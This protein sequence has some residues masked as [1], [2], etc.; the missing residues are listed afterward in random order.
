MHLKRIEVENFKSFG[1]E[2]VIPFDKGFTAI[3]GPNG[4]GK[5]NSGD[6]IQFVLGP[7]STKALRASN[8]SELIFNGGGRG[9]AA[10][11]MSVTLVFANVAEHDGRRRLRI[12]ED[13]VSFTR[14]VRLNRKGDPIS[15]FRIGDKPSS[16]TEMRRVLAEAGLRGD[17]YNIVLQG[18]VTN[19]A[20]MTPH[21]RRG[22]LEDVA[23]VTAYDDEIRRATTQRKH[24]ESSIETI[25]LLEDDKKKQLK[26]LS[27]EREQA[28]KY[29]EIKEEF[30]NSRVTLYQS[31]YRNRLDEVS[32][33][34][35]ERTNYSEKVSLLGS[36]LADGNKKL[37]SFDTELV[38]VESELRKA[39]AGDAQ[40]IMESIRQHEIEIE[41]G[42]DR[43]GDQRKI[44]SNSNEE[45]TTLK[46]ELERAMGAKDEA[47]EKLLTAKKSLEDAEQSLID[48][49]KEEAEA[50]KA[51]ESGDKFARDLN[52]ALGKASERV[53]EAQ[54]SYAQAQLES[55]RAEQASQLAS[56][57]L[58]DLE[59]KFEEATMIKDDLELI[60]NDIHENGPESDR[61]SLADD[62]RSLQKQESE[63]RSDRDRAEIRLRD[64]ERELSKAKARQEARSSAPG[65][66]VTIA[67]L[68]RLRESGQISGILGTLGE[69]T[70]PKDP[71]HEEALATALGNGLRSIVVRDDE[72]AAKCI[73]WLREN[74]GGRATFLPLNKLKVS[75]PQGRTLLVARNPGI[76]GFAQDL[77][78]YDQEVEIAV[79]YASRNTLLV[80]SME[81][82]RNNMGGVRMVTLDGSLIE[83]SGAMTGGSKSRG[84]RPSFGGSAGGHSS[85]D[86]HE[87]LVQE[88]NLLYS[89]V[90]A[91]LRETMLNLQDLRNRINNVDGSDHSVKLRNW[92]AD[93]DRATKSLSEIENR[94]SASR[95]EFETCENN[96]SLK[97]S[98]AEQARVALESALQNRTDAAEALQDN[99]PD[100]LSEILRSAERERTEAER[101]KLSCESSI[102]TNESQIVLMNQRV[103]D[104]ETR[105][106]KQEEEID[107]AQQ[108]ISQLES[109]ISTAKSELIE[110]KGKSEQFDEEHQILTNR[111]D[112]L[113]GERAS[114][115]ATLDQLSK[116]RETL[117]SRIDELNSQISQKAT[118]AEETAEELA[119]AGVAIPS[120]DIQ[121]PTIAEAE[122]AMQG[123]ERRLGNLGN[124][125][126]LAIDQY[127]ETAERI[128]ALIE[129]GKTLRSR[130]DHL[131]S[132]AEQLENE[133]KTR[134]MTVFEHVNNN[135]SRVYE[136][137]QPSGSGKLRL[138][139]SKNPFEGGL[140]MACVPPGKSR[141]TRRSALS[142]GEKSMAALAL[143]FAIQDYE[144]SPFYYF[145]EVDQN[146][147][148]FN[149]GRIATLCRIRSER[150]QFI[151]VTLR[152]VSLSLADH[153]IG[154][155]H[156]GDGCSRRITDFD[157]AAAIELS[158]E[159]EAEKRAQEESKAEKDAMPDLPDPRDM[160]KV[161]EPLHTPASLGGLAERAGI[162]TEI[163]GDETD[164]AEESDS[165]MDSLR[166][167]TGEWTEDIDEKEKVIFHDTED[168]EEA[169]EDPSHQQVDANEV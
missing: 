71:S 142:G 121:L 166:E 54:D 128:A 110:L 26:Q 118:L 95:S 130:R 108:S 58:A 34:G 114:L 82:A 138:E 160:P 42:S 132:I 48:S 44:I 101:T 9:K 7:K 68:T 115:R 125:N 18:D 47:N 41:T 65:S 56:E 63:L 29:K 30:D 81:V 102:L 20:T 168:S 76:I 52:R 144:P 120:E 157:R 21:K 77:L 147:D 38:S 8:V 158:E 117:R 109:S 154:I 159:L 113:V 167:R 39:L 11:H 27:K 127:D 92:K 164:S 24:V 75:R 23:G 17:G 134:F 93:M 89:T 97:I 19:L 55:D 155:T 141:N 100:H 67:A 94:M 10:K 98:E 36:S 116:E 16:A 28:L 99:T 151:M 85:V 1:G 165:V 59:E 133:R 88:S 111:R 87:R 46:K 31:R 43:I 33:L 163:D 50:R 103:S 79:I 104:I 90:D 14:S 37:D 137:L 60:G 83:S 149:S 140:E 35:T 153:H 150:A 119:D 45:I 25:D 86:K 53:S 57:N 4:S 32:L 162:D 148:P 70:S 84:N 146:L 126:M 6:A 78:D 51:I 64:A 105:I 40:R 2:M 123:L 131:V 112:E 13:E 61:S 12:E 72:V 73:K 15:S 49:A 22:V 135:F 96:K 145:D 124:V 139:N 80:Q 107:I 5:S 69:L 66:A 152:K 106:S 129:D 62:L 3:T 136:I 161:P 122:R 143:I 169:M 156:A 74:S 91:A